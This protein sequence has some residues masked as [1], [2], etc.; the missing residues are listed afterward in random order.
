MSGGGWPKLLF[1]NQISDNMDY[2]MHVKYSTFDRK[3]FD[4]FHLKPWLNHLKCGL[5]GSCRYPP[6]LLKA[7][8]SATTGQKVVAP[9]AGN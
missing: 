3:C 1:A 6:S 4:S 7:E 8:M 2:V 5:T 9:Q